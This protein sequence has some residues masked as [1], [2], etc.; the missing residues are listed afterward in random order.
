MTHRERNHHAG[1]AGH[2]VGGARLHDSW[3][4][5]GDRRQHRLLRPRRDADLS[6][7]PGLCE[8]VTGDQGGRFAV[9]ITVP[10][11][12]FP[13]PYK[14]ALDVD[15]KGRSSGPRPTSW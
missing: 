15:C 4:A 12:T 8:S 6:G 14:L 3:K 1:R 7:A 2:L 11:G 13:G 5:G 10:D 9:T